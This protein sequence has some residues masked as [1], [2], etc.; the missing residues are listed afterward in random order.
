LA[1]VWQTS[2]SASSSLFRKRPSRSKSA[3]FW[4]T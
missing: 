3:R 1:P 4:E 2:T